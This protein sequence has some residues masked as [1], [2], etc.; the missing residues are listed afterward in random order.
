MVELRYFDHADF[1]QL[2]N[3]VDSPQF[4]IQWAGPGFTYPLD[5]KQL[6]RYLDNANE[7]GATLYIYKVVLAETGKVVGHISLD[8]I[9]RV[10]RSARVCRVL[11]GDKTVRGRGVGQQMMDAILKIAF[12]DLD[13]HRVSLGVFDFNYAAIACYEKAGFQKEGLKRDV[14]KVG[15]AY[16]SLWEMSILEQ[17]WK[18]N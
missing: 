9:D 17:E 6:E 8:K 13:M 18:A 2:I 12:R 5:E 4:L 3:W 1:K 10:N 16:W 7:K 11:V 15:D 14:A